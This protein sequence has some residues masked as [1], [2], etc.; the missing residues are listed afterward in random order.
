MK[1]NRV[2]EF[3]AALRDGGVVEASE[4]DRMTDRKALRRA[5]KR[6]VKVTLWRGYHRVAKRSA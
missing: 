5:V 1:K 6:K 3:R 4:R 2:I